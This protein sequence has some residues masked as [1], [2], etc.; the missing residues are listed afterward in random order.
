MPYNQPRAF[1]RIATRF[2][3]LLV[4][5]KATERDTAD[6]GDYAGKQ[7]MVIQ[8]PPG[9][10]ANALEVQDSTGNVS[11]LGKVLF[12]VDQNGNFTQGGVVTAKQLVT[13][14][15]LTAA[16]ITTLHSVPVA[17]VAAPGAGIA[18]MAD[19]FLF[20][21][22]YGTVQFTGGGAVNPVYHGATTNHLAGS[23]AAATIQAAANA[24][25][26][27]GALATAFALSANTGIDLYAASADFAAGDSTAICTLW[28]TQYTL[29]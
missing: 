18:L 23:V 19:A 13:Q 28:Y 9:Q 22:K 11:G 29:G 6:F 12:S 3:R 5:V 2:N 8:L 27:A 20:Q 16:Q 15:T 4:R 10:T 17:L 21:F 26:S 25:I 24:T 1:N 14:V 7:L